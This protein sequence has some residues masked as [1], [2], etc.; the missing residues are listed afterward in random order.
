[1]SKPNAIFIGV[2]GGATT[3]KIAAVREDASVVSMKLLQRSTNSENGPEGVIEAW[4]SGISEF[5]EAH[6][7]S[8]RQVEGVGVAVPGPRRS[9]G[10]LDVSPNLPESFGGWDVGADLSRALE[11]AAGRRIRL[12]LGNDG[13]L[14]GVA[15]AQRVHAE[16]GGGAVVMLAP[17]SGLG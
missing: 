10:V 4:I 1:M 9:Y 17:G 3:S 15:E 6:D 12:V 2:D 14:G 16:N 8:W 13:N 11:E 5:L 7:L